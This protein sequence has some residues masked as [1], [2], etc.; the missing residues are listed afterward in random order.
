MSLSI[1][2]SM[3]PESEIEVELFFFLKS[4]FQ[5][6]SKPCLLEFISPT[7]LIPL[8]VRSIDN[9]LLE[10]FL[11]KISFIIT[12]ERFVF[13]LIINSSNFILDFNGKSNLTFKSEFAEIFSSFTGTNLLK[14]LGC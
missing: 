3:Y 10:K 12:S 5:T 11:E 13:E 4:C 8:F 7:M 2:S 14:F 9:K 6:K 1:F